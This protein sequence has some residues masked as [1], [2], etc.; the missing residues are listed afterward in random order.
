MPPGS[1]LSLTAHADQLAR[2]HPEPYATLRSD[3]LT[4]LDAALGAVQPG[5]LLQAALADG[6]LRVDGAAY[7]LGDG[8]GVHV[9]AL[10]D[11]APG[12]ARAARKALPEAEGLVVAPTDG[13]LPG[14]TWIE[15][16]HPVPGEASVR[17]GE[18][19]QRFVEDVGEDETLLALVTGGTSALLEA[20]AVPLEDLQMTTRTLLSRGLTVHEVNMLRKHLSEVKGG[21][22]AARCRG[23]VV[24]LAISDVPHDRVADIGSGPTVP[25]PTTFAQTE[26]LV[27]RLGEGNLPPVV[28]ERVREGA[29]G[30]VAETP[31]PED[32]GVGGPTHLLAT[33]RD[34]LDAA[35]EMARELG[36]RATV[37]PSPME[38]QA[39]VVGE[40]LAKRLVRGERA[41]MGGGEPTVDL[42]AEHE[43]G[44]G[45]GGRN[46]ELTLAAAAHLDGAEAVVASMGSD[47]IDGPT[48]AA[49]AVADGRTAERAR[50][51]GLDPA[52]HLERNDSYPFFDELD[53][54][55]RTGPT[56]TNVMD[57]FVGLVN[58]A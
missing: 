10:G 42:R 32:P 21:R 24:T 46:Q 40:S 45:K 34:A 43:G 35:E 6:V 30:D 11:G 12:F 55:L 4:V 23:R 37:L 27:E 41:L 22:L 54:L 49:G 38:G 36:Y 48:D 26:A 18:A 50:E 51:A 13:E 9:L 47:G 33:N 19:A 52:D 58:E 2:G 15:G 20:P 25:D 17:A 53:D 1:E 57:V 56:G 39:R 5:P 8:E 7:E 44:P 28:V 31:K 29:A 3:L 16:D 14:W